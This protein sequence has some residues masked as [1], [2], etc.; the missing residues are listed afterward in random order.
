VIIVFGVGTGAATV[1]TSGPAVLA[2]TTVSNLRFSRGGQDNRLQYLG[3]K[4]ICK[5]LVVLPLRYQFN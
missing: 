1:L 3:I 4:E 5:K 2:G